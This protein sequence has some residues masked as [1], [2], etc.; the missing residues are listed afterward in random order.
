MWCQQ[1][2]DNVHNIAEGGLFSKFYADSVEFPKATKVPVSDI[3]FKGNTKVPVSDI[4]F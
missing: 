2:F 1:A 4:K 3:K